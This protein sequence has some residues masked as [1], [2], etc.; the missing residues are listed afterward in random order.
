M[1]SAAMS[2]ALLVGATSLRELPGLLASADL[3]IG[4]NSGPKHLAAGLGVPT[5]GVHSGTVDARE[6]GP[7]GANAI[8]VRKN[9][10]CS[11]CYFSDARDCP[12]ELACL[13]QLQPFDVYE[14]CRRFL[15]IETA[16]G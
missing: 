8:A 2:C 4:N 11:P 13:T 7:L 16:R 15:A 9:M 14:I 12:R 10:V 3:F 6:W 1:C 5:V